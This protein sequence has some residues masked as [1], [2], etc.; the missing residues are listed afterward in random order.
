MRR[1]G[2]LPFGLP[3]QAGFFLAGLFQLGDDF[4]PD[5][6][7][8]LD[9]RGDIGKFVHGISMGKTKRRILVCDFELLIFAT[10]Q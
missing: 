2:H 1:R 4:L 9:A 7:F 10:L 5:G 6:F 3:L 8:G